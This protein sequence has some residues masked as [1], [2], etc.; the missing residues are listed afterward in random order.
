MVCFLGQKTPA[1]KTWRQ[2]IGKA[3]DE[4]KCVIVVWSKSSIESDWVMEEADDGRQRRILI[5][6]TIEDVVPPLGFR[7]IQ[8][9]NLSDWTGNPEHRR[10]K[11]LLQ[12]IEGIAG[13]SPQGKSPVETV[14]KET[15]AEPSTETGLQRQKICPEAQDPFLLQIGTDGCLTYGRCR[16]PNCRLYLVR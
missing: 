8:H 9:E 14:Q 7:S 5:P 13:K 3:L 12:S 6:V 11:S 4:A 16:R 15:T 2:Y 1:G 10:A